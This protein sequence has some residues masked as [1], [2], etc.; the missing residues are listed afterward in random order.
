MAPSVLSD[1]RETEEQREFR[2][3]ISGLLV[4]EEFGGLG[5]TRIDAVIASEELGAGLAPYDLFGSCMSAEV[6]LAVTDPGREVWLR[7][8]AEDARPVVLLWPGADASW[9]VDGID[10]GVVEG[11]AVA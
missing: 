7:R 2:A 3:S 10:V 5:G 4:P 6:L 1:Y 8:L 9:N 11:S